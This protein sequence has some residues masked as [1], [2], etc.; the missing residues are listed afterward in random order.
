[1]LSTSPVDALRHTRGRTSYAEID[2]W[3]VGKL[4]IEMVF[5]SRQPEVQ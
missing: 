1:L 4:D 5:S 3:V 2:L